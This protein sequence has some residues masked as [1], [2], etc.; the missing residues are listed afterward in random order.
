VSPRIAVLWSRFGPYHIARLEAAGRRFGEGGRVVG[1]EVSRTDDTYAWGVTH[2]AECFE[3]V[4]IFPHANYH[5]LAPRRIS[6]A[7]GGAL[8]R[9]KPEAV[10]TVGWSFPEARAAL[11]WC[12][13]NGQPAICMSD[14]K[15]DDVPR[16]WWKEFLKR[17]VIRQFE[18]ALVGGRPHAE[19]AAEL[20]IPAE[21]I[22]TGYDVVD[23]GYFAAS[24]AEVRRQAA[25]WRREL[26]LPEAFFLTC[27]RFI[28]VKNLFRLLDAYATYSVHAPSPWGLVICGGGELEA[29]LKGQAGV[30]GLDSVRWPGFVQVSDLPK[31]YALASAFILPSIKD[32]WGLVVNEAMASGLPVLVS[33]KVG[34]RY[35]LVEDGANGYL[36][37]PFD[38]DDMADAMRRMAALSDEE[39]QAMGRRSEAIIADWGPERFAEGLW[40]A[41]GAACSAPRQGHGLIQRMGIRLLTHPRLCRRKSTS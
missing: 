7:I 6:H 19:Y 28:P 34:C 20:G 40:A 31:Y 37:D 3:R 10:A 27:T 25:H 16:R 22:F 35:D 18:A 30:L 9:I 23:N 38:V 24:A 32:T 1:L 5:D 29:E 21:R 8:G 14:S 33:E 12:R 13:L 4:T 15:R 2:G 26:A 36:F 39:R 17:Q 41:V 11:R